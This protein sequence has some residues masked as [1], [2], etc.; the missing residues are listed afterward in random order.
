MPVP[1]CY[2]YFVEQELHYFF[3]R[4]RKDWLG[5]KLTWNKIWVKRGSYSH[6]DDN[7][8]ISCWLSG[9]RIKSYVVQRTKNSTRR[10][11]SGIQILLC[12]LKRIFFSSKSTMFFDNLIFEAHWRLKVEVKNR[13]IRSMCSR[14]YKKLFI[15][16]VCYLSWVVVKAGLMTTSPL[17]SN[18]EDVWNVPVI[19]MC[20]LTSAFL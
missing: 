3:L 7:R 12:S 4:Y 8:W 17:S 2:C 20:A 15:R 18:S 6:I 13:S 1:F 9:F 10:N 5:R 19:S 14:C 11:S 16:T